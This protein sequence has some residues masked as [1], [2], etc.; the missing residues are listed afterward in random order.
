MRRRRLAVARL[1]F[2]GNAF[3]PIAA[4]RARFEAYE[5]QAGAGVLDAMR[6]TATELGAVAQFADAH[7]EWEVVVLRCAAA[8][9]AGPITEDVYAAYADELQ[10][11]LRAGL[12]DGGWDAVYLSLHGAAI[13]V[14]DPTPELRIARLVRSI[15]PLAPVGASF[16]LHG[17]MDPAW[18]EVLDVASVYR[19]HPHVD[20]DATAGRV[21]DGLRRC[22]E[23]GLRTRR[24]LLNRGLILP[25]M[26]MR[27]AAGPMRTIEQAA[28]SATRAPVL[29]VNVFGGFP[30][31]DTPATGASVFVVSDAAQDPAGSAAAAAA[32]E[33]MACI[34]ALAPAFRVTL[35]SPAEALADALGTQEAGLIAITDSADNP[36]SGG[37]GDT[38]GLFA[39]LLAAEPKVPTLFASFATPEA[40]R[41]AWAAG[42]DA[43]L[44]VTLGGR[45]GP[46]FGAPVSVRVTVEAL[47]EGRFRN[48]G[49]MQ[50]GVQ[51]SCGRT[52]L[53]RLA[54]Q[55]EVRVIVTQDVAAADDP[56]FYALHGVDPARLRLLCVKA[57][58]H[59]RAAFADRCVRIIDCDAPGPACLDLSRLPFRHR[60]IAADYP[61]PR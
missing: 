17:N 23:E 33:V 5:W 30:Y 47:T 35:P 12:E 45:Y 53:L 48:V 4:D 1:W 9:P 37:G 31:A 60:H 41:A 6:G 20:M 52:A 32:S 26:N 49:P 24:A 50:T 15:V 7:P 57:K 39:A 42:V 13:T 10:A 61:L 54:D 16:D 59:F 36:L 3:G 51:R 27:T 43:S 2:E 25:S 11:G 38:T 40:V 28:R 56:A 46:Q 8:L 21:L 14:D 18:A 22:A 55:P 44:D 19:T 34:E 58:N 29:D